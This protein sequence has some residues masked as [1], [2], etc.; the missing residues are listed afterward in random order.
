[1]DPWLT[2]YMPLACLAG[3]LGLLILLAWIDL[4]TWLLPD[5]YVLG[6]ALLGIAFHGLTGFR[7]LEPAQM[8]AGA[9]TGGGLLLFIRT[10]GNKVMKQDTLGLGDVKLLAAG[11]LWL[12]F[13]GVTAAITLGALAGLAHGLAVATAIS[14]KHKTKFNLTRLMIPAGPG[15]VVGIV[16]AGIWFLAPFFDRVA[17]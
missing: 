15:F 7:Y 8:M 12:G 11:G 6:V 10:V 2:L 4:K 13:S 9:L 1:M 5:P 3:T 14:L 16:L 17:S